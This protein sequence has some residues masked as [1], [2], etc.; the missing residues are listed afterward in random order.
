MLS[1][2]TQM[3]WN[4]VLPGRE[5]A[6]SLAGATTAS[7]DGAL[8]IICEELPT[9]TPAATWGCEVNG[10]T[11]T[12]EEFSRLASMPGATGDF[13]ASAPGGTALIR[14]LPIKDR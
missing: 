3:L 6:F 14:S 7:L 13:L 12:F 2:M 11:V 10:K 9:E 1:A 8:K 4:A 5:P